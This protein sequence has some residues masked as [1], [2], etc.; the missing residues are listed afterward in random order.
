MRIFLQLQPFLVNYGSNFLVIRSDEV[1]TVG[2]SVS[3]Y[4]KNVYFMNKMFQMK[5]L[6][7]PEF[8]DSLIKSGIHYRN[9]NT[10]YVSL[11]ARKCIFILYAFG[12][13]D[14]SGCQTI[15]VL[16]YSYLLMIEWWEEK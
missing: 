16:R 11:I 7:T 14:S 10:L 1:L 2:Q 15:N 9:K 6:D 8:K 13:N 5:P 4:I 3:I 12:L